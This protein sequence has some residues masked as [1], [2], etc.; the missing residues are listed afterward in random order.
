MRHRLASLITVLLSFA[1]WAAADAQT[2]IISE[3]MADNVTSAERDED[4]ERNDW[5]ELQNTSASAVNLNGW[6]LT[7]DASDLRKWRFPTTSPVISIA[8]GGRLVVWCSGKDRKANITRLHTNFKLDK[9]GEYLGLVRSDGVT[10]EHS[11]GP[12]YPPQFINGTY[13]VATA[14]TTTILLPET[15]AGKAHVPLSDNDYTVAMAGWNS[16]VNFDDSTWQSGESGFGFGSPFTGLLGAG[17]DVSAS[18]QNVNASLCVRFKFNVP[19]LASVAAVRLKMKYDDGFVAFLNG[20]KIGVGLAPSD[21]TW[22][23]TNLLS[24]PRPDNSASTFELVATSNAQGALVQGTNLMAFQLLNSTASDSN[25]LVRPQFEMDE[26][27]GTTVGYL[28]TSTRGTA[29][30]AVATAIGPVVDEVTNNPTRPVGGGG[31]APITITAKVTPTMRPLATTNPVVLKWRRMYGTE[32]SVNMVFNAGTGLYSGDIPTTSLAVGEML[33]WRIEARDNGATPTYGYAPEYPFGATTPPSNPPAKPVTNTTSYVDLDQYYGTV[34]ADGI[35]TSTLPVLHW[36]VDPSALSAPESAAGEPCSFFFQ[37]I[38]KLPPG[39][40]GYVQPPARFYD[41]IPVTIHG[42]SSGGFPQ[43]SHNISFN[44]DNRFDWKDGEPALR[45]VNLLSTYADKT[46]IRNSLAWDTWSKSGHLASHFCVAVRVQRNAAF[47][48]LYDMTEDGNEDYLQRFG[49]DPQGSLYKVYNSLENANPTTTNGG[50]SEKKNPDTT[51]FSDLQ[52]LVD[53]VAD[54][55]TATERLRYVYDNVDVASLVNFLAMHT[56]I[57]NRDTGHKNYYVFRDTATT[58]EWSALPWDQDL[59]FGHTWTGLGQGYFDDDIH[60]GG[61]LQ[62][63]GG[64]KLMR[65]VYGSPELNAMFVARVRSLANQFLV[66]SGETNG[67]LEQKINQL[68]NAIDPNPGNP[69]AGTDDADFNTR[70]WGFWVDGSGGQIGFADSRMADHTV[71]AQADRVLSNNP[72]P[73]YPGSNP[74]ADFQDNSSSLPAFLPGR[75]AFMFN[76][77]PPVSGSLPLPPT[78]PS[79]PDL[80]IESITFNPGSQDQ[81]YFIIRNNSTFAVD[82]SGWQVSGEVEMTFRGGTVIPGT[83][84]TTLQATNA[85]YKNQLIVANKPLGIRQRSTSPKANEYRQ[86]SGPYKGQLSARGGTIVLSRPNNLFDSSAGYTQ[87]A[88]ATYGGSPTVSQQAL[89]ISELNYAPAAPTAAESQALPGVTASDFEFIEVINTGATT[90]NVA[91]AKFDRGVEFVFPSGAISSMAP[92]ARRLIV[93]NLAAFHVRYGTDYDSVILGEYLGN[94][95]NGGEELQLLDPAGEVVLE[96]D[97]DDLWYPLADGAGRSLES[98]SYAYA[99]YGLAASWRVSYGNG[100]SP[101]YEDI[102]A[103]I[104]GQPSSKI[105]NPSQLVTFSVSATGT[106]APKYQWRKG[107]QNL[108]GQTN[109][110]LQFNASESDE[111]SY[112]VV[113]YNAAA[114]VNSD[115]VTLTVNDPVSFNTHPTGKTVNPNVVVTFGVDVSGTGPFTYQWRKGGQNL[116]GEE[117]TS[118]QVTAA[119]SLEGSYDVVVTNVVGPVASNPAILSVNDPVTFNNQPANKTV[120]PG[121]LVTFTADVSGTGPFTYQWRKGGQ[122]LPGEEGVNLQFTAAKSLEGSYDVVVTNTVGSVPSNPA[123]LSVNDPVTINSHPLDKTVNPGVSVT[124]SVDVSGTAPFTYQWRKGGQNLPG[125][126]SSSLQL[127]ATESLEGSYDVVV[128]NVV[129]PATSN[130]ATLSVNDGVNITSQPKAIAINL[131]GHATFSVTAAGTGT[132]TY[133]WRKGGEA[134]DNAT[135][136]TYDIPVVANEHLGNYD[137]VITNIV[138]SVTSSTVQLRLVDWVQEVGKFEGLLAGADLADPQADPRPGRVNV[139]LSKGGK[140]TGQLEYLGLKHPFKATL[141]VNVSAVVPVVRKNLS[142]VS[143]NISYDANTDE[144]S[145]EVSHTD[146]AGTFTST[147]DIVRIPVRPKTAP[148]LRMGRYTLALD[149]GTGAPAELTASGFL[150][151]NVAK[152]GRVTWIGKLPDAAVVKGSAGLAG[153]DTI[154]FYS[155]L[156]ATKLPYVGTIAGP[157]E[158]EAIPASDTTIEGDLAW[159][160]PTQLKAPFATGFKTLVA[161][162]GGLYVRPAKGVEVIEENTLQLDL[163]GPITDGSDNELVQLT[164]ENKFLIVAPNLNRVKLTLNLTTGAMTGSYFDASIKKNRKLEGVLLQNE[165]RATGIFKAPDLLSGQ[166]TTGSWDLIDD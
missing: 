35:T 24:I 25:A 42:Q 67:P 153:D 159:R 152:N 56:L 142:P 30:T 111:G 162:K 77:A 90:L 124:F 140:I 48:G 109:S 114:T 64:N 74:Y 83:S 60:S 36:F 11:Y 163:V 157:L 58:G 133:Q 160:K 2:V 41:A 59:S 143:L 17:G 57:L 13:G 70:Q 66:S 32:T 38:A 45:S 151:V 3:F 39:T 4:G 120:N 126:E 166:D 29:N 1:L 87:V 156:Y 165:N 117:G 161:A 89:R 9:D 104:N 94:L 125:K 135:N 95:S 69:A 113:V 75:R 79:N 23:S 50:G 43:K 63:A 85:S 131:G 52:A 81:E 136:A 137:V 127:T 123:T 21:L 100:G 149:A 37:P 106:P 40:P 71:R 93:S 110:T 86:V 33:R 14:Y 6:Y 61:P 49:L 20:T 103:A 10:V 68:L 128:T 155:P 91:N 134:I 164:P 121:A 82:L 139:T 144:F 84:A 115:P 26:A 47:R 141:D 99:D 8:A 18:M 16:S 146:Q 148:P 96:F 130:A 7:D 101:G 97:Y 46:K 145:F 65:V 27:T 19:N 107:G 132:L 55:R 15:S 158:I 51:D 98:T 62:L 118:L 76:A 78:E 112:D 34:A 129:G 119:E 92:G 108:E 5:L 44:K 138:G 154:A 80:I 116:P 28:S 12:T 31:S 73:T 102:A 72:H 22:N 122:P 54:A 147:G 105:T 88:T 53:G 150:T